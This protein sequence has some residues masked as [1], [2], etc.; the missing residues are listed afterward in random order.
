[1]EKEILKIDIVG[2]ECRVGV[3]NEVEK[4]RAIKTSLV[5]QGEL[6]AML[7]VSQG[8]RM[9][10]LAY[11]AMNVTDRLCREQ[12]AMDNLRLQ[13]TES[14]ERVSKLE[15][16]LSKAREKPKSRKK[17]EKNKEDEEKLEDNKAEAV[18]SSDIVP[19]IEEA[20]VKE[21]VK[22]TAKEAPVELSVPTTEKEL[23]FPESNFL[24]KRKEAVKDTRKE[25]IQE[26][27]SLEM[28]VPDS[29][30]KEVGVAGIHLE[31]NLG[32]QLKKSTQEE[33]R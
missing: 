8:S 27:K 28:A 6:D 18:K 31:T 2:Q 19:E 16:E 1:M 23:L 25:E 7:K 14:A 29:L 12:E 20:P 24:E 17:A 21:A 22:E 11:A 9:L 10:A 3:H 4:A 33:E 32:E 26:K 5:L 13:I 30:S 15:R